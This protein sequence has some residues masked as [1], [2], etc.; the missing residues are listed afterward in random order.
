MTPR[1]AGVGVDEPD[2][3]DSVVDEPMPDAVADMRLS[4]RWIW[5]LLQ[6]RDGGPLAPETFLQLSGADRSTWTRASADLIASEI[7]IRI[8]DV[9]DPD[10][11]S[12]A[13]VDDPDDEPV[14]QR[15]RSGGERR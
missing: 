13:L 8:D 11:E 6:R 5:V 1:S 12:L 10:R 15:A 4:A 2:A 9:D 14:W 3:G 7:A